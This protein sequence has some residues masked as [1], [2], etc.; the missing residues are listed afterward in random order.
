[1]A[2]LVQAIDLN[3]EGIVDA[4]RGHIE[5]DWAN[6]LFDAEQDTLLAFDPDGTLAVF[7]SAWGIEPAE[8]VEV[9]INVHPDHRGR[10]LGTWFVA[11]AE[12]RTRRYSARPE[13]STLLRS[14]VSSSGGG[15]AFLERLGYRHVRTFWH[16]ERRLAG[17]EETGPLPTVC[18]SGR[19]G[20]VTALWSI[21]SSR[22]PSRGSSV[23]SA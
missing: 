10:G 11:W 23:S 9:W 17:T 21:V 12:A 20:T 22:R 15:S 18:R 14:A 3:D 4:V 8:A 5:D 19:I 13:A 6:P 1:M 2:A 7:A 16:M